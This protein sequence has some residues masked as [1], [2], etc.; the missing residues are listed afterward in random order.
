MFNRVAIINRGE[1]AMRL[2]RAARE[3]EL[4]QGSPLTT[5]ALYTDVDRNSMFV[6]AADE[7]MRIHST[8]MNAY[9]DYDVVAKALRDSRADA[10]WVGWGFVSEDPEFADRVEQMGLIFIGPSAGVMRR[11]GDKIGAKRLAEEVGV[12]V[13]PWSDGPVSSKEEA[14][15]H[16]EAIGFPLMIKA[17][18]GGGG[19]GIRRVEDAG[20]VGAAFESARREAANTFGDDTL[21]IERVIK[22]GRHVEVQVVADGQGGVWALGVR[23]C[24]IQRR[25]Q[26]VIEESAS[27]ALD[28][29]G[30]QRAKAGAVALAEV[31]GYRG[32]ATVEYLY[33]PDEDRL[34]F[35]EVNT[36][37]QVEHP[38]TEITTGVD[39]VK[40]QLY[41]ADGGRLE[42]DP[43]P[44]RG[45]AIEVRLNAEDPE[46]DF[47]PAP[48]G[49]P[50]SSVGPA[51]S[52]R[53]GRLPRQD[54]RGARP[55][56]P[57]WS[58]R[59]G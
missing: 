26:K 58:S 33:Q 44:P 57:C 1:A 23:D 10:V 32:V 12:H 5:I 51:S 29:S 13:A 49:R 17:A 52:Y 59:P 25:N 6:R 20:G 7:A 45:H 28:A 37:L 47:A 56:T 41:L 9:L 8:E 42:G 35:L 4:E 2:I 46:R 36:R 50:R 14:R 30:E 11:L 39:L 15:R 53:T 16:A 54:A 38:V 34:A 3:V 43:P 21:F 40:L 24:S 22:G 18:A 55:R 48:G 27:T 19:R 31:T